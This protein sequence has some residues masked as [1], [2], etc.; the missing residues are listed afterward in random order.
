MNINR[1]HKD[2]DAEIYTHSM[3]DILFF[4]LFFFLIA[5]TL[6]NPN[7]IKLQL[8]KANSNTSSKQTVVVSIDANHQ[9]YVSTK[10]VAY[11]NLLTEI[12][13][14]LGNQVDPAIVINAEKSV[15]IED[16]VKV[17]NI[18]KELKVKVVLAT[19]PL[20]NK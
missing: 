6:A 19:Q 4:L 13:P 2:K 15:P 11:E 17:M 7:V 10:A 3:S 1:R 5:A 8:P 9:F 12:K 20:N 18:A 16:V 14:Y